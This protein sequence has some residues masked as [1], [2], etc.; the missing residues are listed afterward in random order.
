MKNLLPLLALTALMSGAILTGC[1]KEAEP[2]ATPES[3]KVETP[4]E[5]SKPEDKSAK[6]ESDPNEPIVLD[7]GVTAPKDGEEV[8]ILETY[9]GK[10]VLAFDST[11]APKTVENFKML[12][13]K[14]FY[15]GTRFHRCMPGFMVQGGDPN[16]KDLAKS[17]LWGSGGNTDESGKEVNI[18]GEVK[19]ASH[20]RGV[21]SMANSGTPESASSQFFIVQSDST[22]LDGGYASFGRG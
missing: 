11:A 15:D 6:D 10:I 13:K 22:F 16:S 19:G 14:G 18:P 17:Q 2:V 21:I 9:K 5:E 3:T 8:A 12:V 7:E 4:V 20:K 1:A